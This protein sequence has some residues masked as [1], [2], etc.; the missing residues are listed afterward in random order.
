M[1]SFLRR[2]EDPA[3]T[4]VVVF[5]CTPV[6]RENYRLGVPE[7]GWWR[8]LLN[9]DADLYGGSGKGNGGGVNSQETPCHGFSHCLNLTLPPLGAL[10]LKRG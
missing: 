9:S 8:E 10:F 5:N 4:V 7:G 2:A 6:V 3:D 1:L